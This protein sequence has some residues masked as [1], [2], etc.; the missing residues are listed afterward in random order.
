M[1]T[2]KQYFLSEMAVAPKNID[3]EKRYDY[4]NKK[5]FGGLLPKIPITW[6]K[7]KSAGGRAK[8]SIRITS[9][10]SSQVVPSGIEL[11]EYIIGD[12]DELDK[13]LLHEMI[14]IQVFMSS[15]PR[16]G[17]GFMFEKF[18]KEAIEKSGIDIPIKEDVS[19]WKFTDNLKTKPIIMMVITDGATKKLI[20]WN[21]SA[22][23]KNLPEIKAT[24]QRIYKVPNAEFFRS[25][26]KRLNNLTVKRTLG[27]GWSYYQLSSAKIKEMFDDAMKTATKVGEFKGEQKVA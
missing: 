17:H 10:V 1:K 5:V 27:R 22:F 19:E 26:S 2:F 7:S 15:R 23:N 13:I 21:E 20:L 18:R 12:P 9:A 14:H 6:M 4:W 3:L 16:D 8:A 11:S 24:M 25:D